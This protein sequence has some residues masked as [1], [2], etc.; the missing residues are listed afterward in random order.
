M[1]AMRRR[2]LRAL[3]ILCTLLACASLALEVTGLLRE[4]QID[5]ELGKRHFM[6]VGTPHRF[7]IVMWPNRWVGYAIRFSHDD[8]VVP[9]SAGSLKPQVSGDFIAIP[10]W[11]IFLLTAPWPAWW[12]V[13]QRKRNARRL[14]GLCEH[15]GYDLRA[16]PD[17]C[18][19]CGATVDR[20]MGNLPMHSAAKQH[21]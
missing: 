20:G 3:L 14:A 5:F 21:A 7:C 11:L 15:C 17:R 13:R 8:N 12:F 19:E 6:I 9:A 2:L 18:P 16:S 10:Y 4:D 1:V